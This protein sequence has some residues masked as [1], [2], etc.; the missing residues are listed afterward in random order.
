MH[1]CPIVGAGVKKKDPEHWR[2][3]GIV[4]FWCYWIDT[5][6]QKETGLTMLQ[7]YHM[8]YFQE[9][10]N[11]TLEN[12][13][14][15]YIVLMSRG[16]VMQLL[17]PSFY[18]RKWG[19]SWNEWIC[20]VSITP[21]RKAA[22]PWHSKGSR[23]TLPLLTIR[24]LDKI[25]KTILFR[26]FRTVQD[27]D[28]WKKKDKQMKWARQLPWLYAWRR[29]QATAQGVGIQTVKKHRSLGSLKGWGP[30]IGL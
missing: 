21:G 25:Y 27:C 20:L 3:G 16:E 14:I 24:K 26:H 2:Y 11:Q 8:Q 4:L 18:G 23:C 12:I 5:E 17:R 19:L 10:I 7:K 9:W 22:F 1:S 13:L 6:R 30:S 15:L 29:F 28:C